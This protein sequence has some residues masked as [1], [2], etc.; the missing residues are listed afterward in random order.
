MFHETDDQQ[1]ETNDGGFG[2]GGGME[3]MEAFLNECD[4]EGEGGWDDEEGEDGMEDDELSEEETIK[5]ELVALAAMQ[6]A[7]EE[8]KA[9][10]L[11]KGDELEQALAESG[12]T[13]RHYAALL[14]ASELRTIFLYELGIQTVRAK[15]AKDEAS[16]DRVTCALTLTKEDEERVK[17]QAKELAQAFIGIRYPFL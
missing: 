12:S 5:A 8:A 11:L 14:V 9:K 10:Y 16:S 13:K 3:D 6:K 17:K 2:G 1:N 15:L 7:F 4:E